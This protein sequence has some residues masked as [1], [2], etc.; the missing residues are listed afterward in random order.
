[1]EWPQRTDIHCW[2]CTHPFDTCPVPLPVKYDEKR[3]VFYVIGIFCSFACAKRYNMERDCVTRGHCGTLL[4]LM[5]HKLIGGPW[6]C[7]SSGYSIVC[8]PHRNRLRCFGG[9]YT[10]EEFRRNFQVLR[11]SDIKGAV[12][13][14]DGDIRLEDR[15]G[16][17]ATQAS[18]LWD[19]SGDRKMPGTRRCT[20]TP[21]PPVEVEEDVDTQSQVSK[22]ADDG[23]RKERQRRV[24]SNIVNAPVVRNQ[25]YKL[26][27]SKPVGDVNNTLFQSMQLKVEKPT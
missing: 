20:V 4:C 7:D 9:D 13:I 5:R 23:R 11:V 19:A 2:Y 10:I 24:I 1:M 27:R 16:G 22:E 25:P 12:D 15:H 8:A 14:G 3:R 6:A 26:K 21:A 18:S 17:F